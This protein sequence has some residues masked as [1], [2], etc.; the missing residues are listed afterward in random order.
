MKEH[1]PLDQD[2]LLP[3]DRLVGRRVVDRDG[4]KAGRIH[5]V[6]VQ[7]IGLDWVMTHY[8]I[9][10]AGL[11]ERLGV[12]VKLLVGGS[13]SPYVVPVDQIDFSDPKQARLRC[14]RTEL[15]RQ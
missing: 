14:T 13:T 3:L 10:V 15:H 4:Q 9:G 8:V 7:V 1:S 6:R 11:M 5:E 2:R 12:G